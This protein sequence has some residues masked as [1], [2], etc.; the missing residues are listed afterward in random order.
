M[1]VDHEYFL[2]LAVHHSG[3]LWI[4]WRTRFDTQPGQRRRFW[5]ALRDVLP[6]VNPE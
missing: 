6:A 5:G 3:L 2:R 1:N 4:E